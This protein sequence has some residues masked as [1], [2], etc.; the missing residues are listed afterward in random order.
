MVSIKKYFKKYYTKKMVSL[1]SEDLK[2]G[3]DFSSLKKIS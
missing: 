3:I 1:F 2:P